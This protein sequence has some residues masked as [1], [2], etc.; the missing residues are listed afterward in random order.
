MTDFGFDDI[1]QVETDINGLI[2]D[3]YLASADQD[4]IVARWGFEN[5]LYSNFLWNSAQCIEKYL[6]CILLHHRVSVQDLKH[7]LCKARD[8]VEKNCPDVIIAQFYNV[9]QITGGHF[10]C[11]KDTPASFISGLNDAGHPDI[12]YLQIHFSLDFSDLMKLDQLVF[13]LRKNCHSNKPWKP[14]ASSRLEENRPAE[15]WSELLWRHTGGLLERLKQ[16]FKAQDPTKGDEYAFLFLNYP[17]EGFTPSKANLAWASRSSAIWRVL[18]RYR[19]QVSAEIEDACKTQQVLKWALNNM[20]LP[21]K[22][23]DEIEQEIA[24]SS[25]PLSS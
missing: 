9:P 6:K 7:D 11:E 4:Y 10:K 14:A 13:S 18:D 20:R 12:R 17:F 23:R 15:R 5:K 3:T 19:A 8:L 1:D 2:D 22:L 25:L 16:S 21:S 24:R